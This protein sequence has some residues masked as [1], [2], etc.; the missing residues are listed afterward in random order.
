[1]MSIDLLA[2]VSAC[3]RISGASSVTA[4][5]SGNVDGVGEDVGHT[6]GRVGGV[7]GPQ[8]QL[9]GAGSPASPV[10]Q[11]GCRG[12]S[13]CRSPIKSWTVRCYSFNNAIHVIVNSSDSLVS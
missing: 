2:V 9:D 7:V 8:G 12:C 3:C 10:V 11:R 13:L 6:V 1:M 5:T 4:A